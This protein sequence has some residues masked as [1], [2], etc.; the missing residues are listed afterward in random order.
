MIFT[1]DLSAA[2]VASCCLAVA[3]V[4]TSGKL[5]LLYTA[6]YIEGFTQGSTA[7]NTSG[8]RIC[9]AAGGILVYRVDRAAVGLFGRVR[10][11]VLAV[12][13]AVPIRRLLKDQQQG[14]T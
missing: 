10:A 2:A 13:A 9:T 5:W 1:V 4:S 3:S 12:V 8:I 14:V 7:G 6:Y 11:V